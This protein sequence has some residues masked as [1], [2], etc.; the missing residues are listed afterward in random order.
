MTIPEVASVLGYSR[1]QT[2][3]LI[4]RGVLPSVRVSG[5]ALRVPRAALDA[6]LE[7]QAERAVTAMKARAS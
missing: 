3:R 1:R 4:A 5:G 6:W 7:V 2:Y